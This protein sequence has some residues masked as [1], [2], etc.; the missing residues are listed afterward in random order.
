MT[1]LA[2]GNWLNSNNFHCAGRERMCR[3]CNSRNFFIKS[4]L[5]RDF[6]C[7]SSRESQNWT[8]GDTHSISKPGN[9]SLKMENFQEKT[10]WFRVEL[11]RKCL[12][13]TWQLVNLN[14]PR[15]LV[16]G[17]FIFKA[18]FPSNQDTIPSFWARF[19]ILS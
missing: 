12:T 18:T 11:A 3:S 15:F 4:L 9:I 13:C 2:I 10:N 14:F 19:P 16:H 5:F 8:R 7:L 1:L 6:L 17:C